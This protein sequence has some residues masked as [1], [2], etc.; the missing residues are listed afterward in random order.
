[1]SQAPLRSRL[2]MGALAGIAGTFAMTAAM[3]RLHR[4]LP[5]GERYPLPPREITDAIAPAPTNEAAK[6]RSIA[7]HFAFGSAAAALLATPGEPM[8]LRRGIA[9]GLAVWAASYLGWVPGAGILRT[10]DRHPARRTALM[11]AVHIVWGAVTA[12]GARE[13]DRDRATVFSSG[14]QRDRQRS[15]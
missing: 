10:V 9:G 14:P 6:D 5:P 3:D 1:M 11:I 2:L 12:L 7:A 15:A 13:L 4:R 8:T